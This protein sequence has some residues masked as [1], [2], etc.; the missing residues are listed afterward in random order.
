MAVNA[1][2]TPS[3]QPLTSRTLDRLF[4]EQ[5]EREWQEMNERFQ[6]FDDAAYRE[7]HKRCLTCTH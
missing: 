4:E 3:A 6:P 1:F 7:H 5:N 2:M